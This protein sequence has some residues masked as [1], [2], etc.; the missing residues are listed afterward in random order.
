MKE[1][2]LLF[3][4]NKTLIDDEK[5]QK[6]FSS[7]IKN[8]EKENKISEYKNILNKVKIFERDEK[9]LNQEF[10]SKLFYNLTIMYIFIVIYLFL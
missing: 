8:L 4:G 1:K 2:Y 6:E 5:T 9:K 3:K 10:L 7:W